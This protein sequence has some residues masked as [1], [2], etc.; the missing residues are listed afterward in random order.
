MNPCPHHFDTLFQCDLPVFREADELVIVNRST[1]F[2]D[3]VEI[4]LRELAD[5]TVGAANG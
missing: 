1:D 4:G 2:G 5:D 3:T